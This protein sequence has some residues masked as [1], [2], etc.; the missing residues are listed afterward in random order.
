MRCERCIRWRWR[1]NGR[2]IDEHF[3]PGRRYGYTNIH[4]LLK[5]LLLGNN[6]HWALND[7]ERHRLW[8]QEDYFWGVV[9]KNR[10][11]WYRVPTPEQALDFGFEVQPALM[12]ALNQQRL[13]MGCHAWEKHGFDF[14][15]PLIEQQGYQFS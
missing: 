6:T 10:F 1:R 14:W 15:K 12:Y 2:R 13:P 8:Y 11:P 5:A 4:I 3:R 7:F 9:C